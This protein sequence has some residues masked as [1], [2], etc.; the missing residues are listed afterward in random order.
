ML[1]TRSVGSDWKSCS[2]V[3]PG[4]TKCPSL[5]HVG[6]EFC[7]Q[8]QIYDQEKNKKEFEKKPRDIVPKEQAGE[9]GN[10]PP[11]HFRRLLYST[12]VLMISYTLPWL[13]RG[14]GPPWLERGGFLL[15]EPI[16]IKDHLTHLSTVLAD[17]EIDLWGWSA[18]FLFHLMPYIF[19]VTFILA[20]YKYYQGDNL[21]SANIGI[22]HTGIFGVSMSLYLISRLSNP[23]YYIFI[24]PIGDGAFEQ[25]FLDANGLWLAGLSGLGLHPKT[26]DFLILANPQNIHNK[27]TRNPPQH[28]SA[29]NSHSRSESDIQLDGMVDELSII[30]TYREINSA[31]YKNAIIP[32]I[33]LSLYAAWLFAKPDFNT[34]A[35]WSFEPIQYEDYW[36]SFLS[37]SIPLYFVISIVLGIRSNS[38][39]KGSLFRAQSLV[40]SID[41]LLIYSP[42][43]TRRAE[44]V[45]T[46]SSFD[47]ATSTRALLGS[48]ALITAILSILLFFL[49]IFANQDRR[50]Y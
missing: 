42:N 47:Q 9:S 3:S 6:S 29:S 38:I 23:E 31:N 16:R 26:R 17:V 25:I 39:G 7:F 44:Y 4:G 30:K 27:S 22:L 37:V 48:F 20:W 13:P 15:M 11:E 18:S 8:H 14:I 41:E 1:L 10:E 35:S 24:D 28:S 33:V 45:I 49:A 40:K 5:P 46:K 32:T 50:R 43:Y 21:G 2:Y 12:A 19:I 36:P 34:M